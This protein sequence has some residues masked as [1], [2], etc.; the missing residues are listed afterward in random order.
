MPSFAQPA[1]DSDTPIRMLYLGHTGA[2]KTGSLCS[3]ASAGYKVRILDID[4]GVEI[5]DGFMRDGA[6]PYLKAHPS[7]LWSA[8][9]A[10]GAPARMSYVTMT[11]KYKL[12]GTKAVPQ[13]QVWQRIMN[14][15][16]RWKD[17]DVDLGPIT[18][19]G[20]DTVLVFDG[21]SRLAEAAMNLQLALNG[22]L[23][24]GP[25]VGTS[26]DNDYT[27]AYRTILSFLDL[28][29]CDE[30]KCHIIMIC[31]IQFIEEGTRQGNMRGGEKKGFPQVIGPLL[32]PRIGQYFNHTIRAKQVGNHPSVKRVIVTNNDENIELKNARPLAIKA[33]YPLATGLAEYFRDAGKTPSISKT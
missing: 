6:S 5:I 13:G 18:E 20:Q 10:V 24:S 3:L 31:H 26:G 4:K 12:Q 33:E 9:L 11:E 27:H 7:G 8:E 14:Q 16:N 28:L 25:Q 23:L 1:V 17:G 29:K 22:R 21:L 32:A 19:W 30:I 2:G 15:L